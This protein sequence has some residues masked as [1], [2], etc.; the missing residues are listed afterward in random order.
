LH[1]ARGR[2][3]AK[4]EKKYTIAAD[5]QRKERTFKTNPMR[6]V[7][8]EGKAASAQHPRAPNGIRS[9]SWKSPERNRHK[10]RSKGRN[11]KERARTM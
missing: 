6:V 9:P 3:N 11:G 10:K 2:E 7:T 8:E 4:G 5:P 1:P